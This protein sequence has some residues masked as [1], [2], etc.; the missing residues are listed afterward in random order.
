MGDLPSKIE[1]AMPFDICTET[2]VQI[3][4]FQTV[5]EAR[6]SEAYM[7]TNFFAVLVGIRKQDQGAGKS[8]Y[9]YAPLQDFSIRWT[10]E[11]LYEKY[12]LTAKQID[13]INMIL[14]KW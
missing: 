10:D 7:R 12:Q 3:G 2:F 1:L 11:M 13:Y 9:H 8:V 5:E 14:N 6:N 4:P